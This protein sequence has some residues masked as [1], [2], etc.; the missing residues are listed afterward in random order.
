MNPTA[1]Q[2]D[3]LVTQIAQS[4]VDRPQDVLVNAVESNHTMVLEL[5]VAKE[6]IG[7]VIGKQGRTAQAMR[8]LVGA[9]SAK[10]KKRTTL[11]I[12]E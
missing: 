3:E 11:E 10:L 8:T 9:V 12:V 2:M 6:D 7:K 4:L 1:T 5:R